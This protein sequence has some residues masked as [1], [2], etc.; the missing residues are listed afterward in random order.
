MNP[1]DA[2][3]KLLSQINVTRE[4]IARAKH[5]IVA[6]IGS[7]ATETGTPD[8]A[9]QWLQREGAAVPTGI[10]VNIEEPGADDALTRLS[11]GYSLRLGFYQAIWE[12]VAACEVLPG[13]PARWEANAGW[14]DSH[15]SAGLEINSINCLFP[16]AIKRPPL[17]SAPA[18]DPDVFLQ[19]ADC[20]T[21]HPGVR[22]AITQ[23]LA[24]FRR[25]LYLPAI[26]MLAAGA[27]AEWIECGTAVA[28][29]LGDTRLRELIE[30]P[31]TSFAEKVMGI[32]R[33]LE[34][35]TSKDL[36][37]AAG[38]NPARVSDSELW[39]TTLRERRNAVHWGKA[40][41]FIAQHSDAASL[42]LSA[43]LHLGTLEAIRKACS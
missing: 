16:S 11:R 19:G 25:G 9:E 38:T 14:R 6:A 18:T 42:L 22:E 41:S 12:L 43:A 40:Q 2:S 4:D 37:R 31:R 13:A 1:H 36:L 26:V 7:A 20:V 33:T 32:K 34:S 8:L 28:A 35:A 21:L 10:I 24:C 27:E 30:R 23:S 29:K 3:R 5:F 15:Y 17:V 39:T